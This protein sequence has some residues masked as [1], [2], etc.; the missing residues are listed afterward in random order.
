MN[1]L[2]LL[3]SNGSIISLID[4]R[5]DTVLKKKFHLHYVLFT[6]PYNYC[7]HLLFQTQNILKFLFHYLLVDNSFKEEFNPMNQIIISSNP[8][9]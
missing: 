3:T 1:L 9:K 6:K 4:N 2:N 5:F 7:I 8:S